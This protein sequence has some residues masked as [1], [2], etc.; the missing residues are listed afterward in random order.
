MKKTLLLIFLSFLLTRLPAQMYVDGQLLSEIF[1][2]KYIKICPDKRGFNN[3]RACVDFG[4]KVI[5]RPGPNAA[6]IT[7][8]KGTYKRFNSQTGIMNFMNKNGFDVFHLSDS[9]NCIIYARKE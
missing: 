4:Q 7:D 9:T 8:D 2:G 6:I 3:F 5:R 1:D